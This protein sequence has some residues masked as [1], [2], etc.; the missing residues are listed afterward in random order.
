MRRRVSIPILLALLL[1]V[2]AIAA[3]CNLGA[4]PQAPEAIPPA[5]TEAPAPPAERVAPALEPAQVAGLY[6]AELPDRR[7][8]ANL[9]EDGSLAVTVEHVDGRPTTVQTGTW[10]VN[11]D[12]SGT[13]SITAQDDRAYFRPVVLVLRVEGDTL[14]VTSADGSV[15]VT[16]R[17]VAPEVLPPA[18]VVTPVAPGEPVTVTVPLTPTA[19][20]TTT[21]PVTPTVEAP[22]RPTKTARVQIRDA[23]LGLRRTAD[24]SGLALY[25]LSLNDDGT[26]R[27][28]M[29]PYGADLPTLVWLGTWEDRGDGTFT[30]TLAGTEDRPFEQPVVITFARSGDLIRAAEWDKATYGEEGLTLRLAAD[31]ATE[32]EQA[33]VT[34]DLTAGF[35]LDPTFVSVNGGGEVDATLLGAGC[36][37]FINDKPVVTVNWSGEA[38][39]ARVFFVSDHDPT[40]VVLAPDGRFFCNDDAHADLLD[41]LIRIDNPPQGTYRIW[42]GSYAKGQLIPGVLVLTTRPEVSLGTFNLADLIKRPVLADEPIRPLPSVTLD[43][44]K[45][46]A[47]EAITLTVD[48][49][50]FTATVTAEGDLPA[51][52]LPAKGARCAGLIS[53]AASAAFR[54][55]GE[56]RPLRILF[57]GDRD[58]T[59]VVVGPGPAVLCNDDAA[60]DNLNPALTVDA[61][62][63]LYLVFVGRVNPSAPVTGTLTVTLDPEATPAP[64]APAKP[65]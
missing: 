35:P 8:T 3:A 15:G 32:M 44:L 26:A 59:L 28:A 5:A 42:I 33:L 34:L 6:R 11:A 46:A 7:I 10:Q 65:Q 54:W 31:L 56:G 53:A 51:A 12:G 13:V 49:A 14:T 1:A 22:A 43:A 37:G 57:E 24:G 55:T 17:R 18:E 36:T 48:S 27:M 9:G 2:G 30:V 52:E 20:I 41:P 23:Y 62:E 25:A 40:L 58:A 64:L 19:P 47:E 45:V 39:L 61:A 21:A 50:P 63:G 60:A 38:E 4:V 16:L 29:E